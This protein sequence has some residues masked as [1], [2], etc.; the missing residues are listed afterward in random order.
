MARRSEQH[1]S[2]RS[3]E[4]MSHYIRSIHNPRIRKITQLRKRRGREKQGRII[5]DGMR[6]IEQALKS[7]LAI[8]ELIGLPAEVERHAS[9]IELLTTSGT[10]V[11][12][13]SQPAWN[14]ICYGDQSSGIIAVADAPLF[15]LERLTLRKNG[16]LIV[17]ED[18]EK[19][20]NI[21]AVLRTADAAGAAAVIVTDPA[22]DLCNPNTI[23]SSIGTLF[24]TPVAVAAGAEARDWLDR[25]KFRILAARVD[26]KL[27]YTEADLGGRVAVVLGS[28]AR[29]LSP[30]WQGSGTSPVVIPM[31]GTS[32]SLNVSVAAA[33]MLYESRRQ[34]D[35][36]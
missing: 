7:G 4:I 19:P 31:Q 9:L 6:P 11:L 13:V 33:I 20:G 12:S 29:G 15:A 34:R 1:D 17:L 14:R 25:Q 21:G 10:D 36:T 16:L 24:T 5:I 2:N 35:A 22:T 23:R 32:D 30:A 27:G 26:G 28:E 8:R 18:V 3:P